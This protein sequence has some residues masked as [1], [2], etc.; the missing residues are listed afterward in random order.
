[1]T[2]RDL[3]LL[4]ALYRLEMAL[5]CRDQ[6]TAHVIT[7]YLL[8]VVASGRGPATDVAP[9]LDAIDRAERQPTLTKH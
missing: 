6:I 7:E 3:D 1:L 2:D 9:A 8:T 4:A 5:D